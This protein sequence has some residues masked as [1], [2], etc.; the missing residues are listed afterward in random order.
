MEIHYTMF[1]KVEPLYTFIAMLLL[2][3]QRETLFYIN[4]L[5][6]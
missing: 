5:Q 4:I 1:D 3:E 2:L 6:G